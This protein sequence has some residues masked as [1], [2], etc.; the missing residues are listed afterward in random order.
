MLLKKLSLGEKTIQA[1]RR[2]RL[3]KEPLEWNSKQEKVGSGYYE[4]GMELKKQAS[5]H[6]ALTTWTVENSHHVVNFHCFLTED[7][8]LI[9]GRVNLFGLGFGALDQEYVNEFLDELAEN[10]EWEKVE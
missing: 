8:K 2:T 6:F 3:N 7:G 10:P 1:S 4:V 5:G 9:E